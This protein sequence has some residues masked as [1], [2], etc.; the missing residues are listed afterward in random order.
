LPTWIWSS[1]PGAVSYDFHLELPNHNASDF[2][3]LP[4]AAAAPVLLKGTGSWHWQVRASFPQ[5]DNLAMTKGAWSERIAFTR[6]IPEPPNPREEVGANRLLL[7][8]DPRLGAVN[9]RV[10]VATTADF[11]SPVETATTETTSYAPKL[12]LP[13]YLAGGTF[14]WRVAAADDLVANVGDYTG[15]RTFTLAGAPLAKTVTSIT[16]RATKTARKVKVS[17]SVSPYATG[18]VTV[19]LYRMRAG[20][21]RWLAT[22][23]PS[24]SGFSTYTT[25]FARP[26][27]GTCKVVS[28]YAGDSSHAGSRRS[29]KFRC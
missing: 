6:T 15:A 19:K 16:A 13:A 21:F 26:S 7:R 22:R 3:G 14:Y 24:L 12:M 25:A 2:T 10:Q 20:S 17:G 28:R 27:A 9:Y 5:V 1:V 4:S 29:A 18:H 23:S 8:W 11:S